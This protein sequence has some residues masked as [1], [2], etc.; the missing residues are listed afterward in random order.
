MVVE[1][2]VTEVT[3]LVLDDEVLV[4]V[5]DEDGFAVRRT[6]T[7]PAIATR[8]ITATATTIFDNPLLLALRQA[9]YDIRVT[10]CE[11]PPLLLK[12]TS[13]HA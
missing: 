5:F 2:V 10:G 9:R 7:A 11:L 3:V 6:P 1:V 13:V 4:E 8:T 12:P